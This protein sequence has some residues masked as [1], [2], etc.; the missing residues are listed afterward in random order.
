MSLYEDRYRKTQRPSRGLI[1]RQ[2]LIARDV[3]VVDMLDSLNLTFLDWK[4]HVFR[5]DQ[6]YDIIEGLLYWG[7]LIRRDFRKT[8]KEVSQLLTNNTKGDYRVCM[9]QH[10]IHLCLE[11][12]YSVSKTIYD[13]TGWAADI[14]YTYLAMSSSKMSHWQT[15]K[16]EVVRSIRVLTCHA[17]INFPDNPRNWNTITFH[18]HWLYAT[19]IFLSKTERSHVN[20]STYHRYSYILENEMQRRKRFEQRKTINVPE[21]CEKIPLFSNYIAFFFRY[22]KLKTA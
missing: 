7:I 8:S 9:N 17:I 6:Q 13:V 2:N 5:A 11:L 16:N 22:K 1:D 10:F 14:K 19:L 12:N 18:A 21:P 3:P 20:G 4:I 15:A